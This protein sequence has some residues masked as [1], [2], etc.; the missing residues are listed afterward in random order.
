[1]TAISGIE[2]YPTRDDSKV[3]L[4][5]LAFTSTADGSDLMVY[6]HKSGMESVASGIVVGKWAKLE[7]RYYADRNNYELY[8]DGNYIMTGSYLRDGG[9][10]PTATE[11]NGVCVAMNSGNAGEFYYDNLYIHHLR[12]D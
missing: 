6:D 2:I 11:L 3:F 5:Y 4:P 8:V 12:I 1:M 10:Y 9:Y 7:I